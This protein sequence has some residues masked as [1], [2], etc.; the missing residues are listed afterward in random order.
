MSDLKVYWQEIRAIE[1][2]LEPSVWLTGLGGAK[3]GQAPG[4]VV[5]VPAAAAAR[6]LHAKLHRL[7][8]EEE[9][10]HHLAREQSAKRTAFHES[11]RARGVAVTPVERATETS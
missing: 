10:Q 7:A 11:L 4:L 9:I 8:T 2:T 6:L 3:R 5:E 1:K